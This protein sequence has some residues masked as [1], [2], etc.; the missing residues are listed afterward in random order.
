[1]PRKGQRIKT[2]K[3]APV[4]PVIPRLRTVD[5]LASHPLTRYMHAHFEWMLMHGY[6]ADTVRARRIALR[7]FIAWCAERDLAELG[8]Q[9]H[10][11]DP[12]GW[13]L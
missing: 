9:L 5:P 3:A 12:Q 4:K 8:R 7:R 6:S 1:M 13:C 2:R 10:G 11:R